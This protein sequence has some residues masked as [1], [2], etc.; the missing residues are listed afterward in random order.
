MELIDKSALIA[1]YTTHNNYEDDLKE[2][3]LMGYKDALNKIN[4]LEEKEVDLKKEFDNY[5]KDILACDV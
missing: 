1:E 2:G 5:T 3:R 4:N